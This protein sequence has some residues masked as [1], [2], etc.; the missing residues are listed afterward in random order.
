[1]DGNHPLN[2]EQMSRLLHDVRAPMTT[3]RAFKSELMES[4]E[5]LSTL[6][7]SLEAELSPESYAKICDILD[8]DLKVCAT[9]VSTSVDNLQTV[10]GEFVEKFSP[11]TD[12]DG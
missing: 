4:V 12:S 5:D 10:I 7:Q 6:I 1:M 11:P 8:Q 3:A 2:A 9:H